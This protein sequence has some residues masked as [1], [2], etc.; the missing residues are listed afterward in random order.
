LNLGTRVHLGGITSNTWQADETETATAYMENELG[1]NLVLAR[2]HPL[3]K[4][5]ISRMQQA[6]LFPYFLEIATTRIV[7][8]VVEIRLRKSLTE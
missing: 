3:V 5:S 6:S 8:V 1:R 4:H 2:K 7:S